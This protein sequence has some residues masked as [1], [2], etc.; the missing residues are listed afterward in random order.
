[1]RAKQ[2]KTSGGKKKLGFSSSLDYFDDCP[3]CRAIGKAER[4]GKELS[5]EEL[6]KVFDD[7]NLMNKN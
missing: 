1:M 6:E 5:L 7:V 4:E 3:I 2:I